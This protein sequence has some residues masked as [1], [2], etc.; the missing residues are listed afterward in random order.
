MTYNCKPPLVFWQPGRIERPD[1]G[2]SVVEKDYSQ[3]LANM[4]KTSFRIIGLVLFCQTLKES[5]QKYF[6]I[7]KAH[8]YFNQISVSSYPNKATVIATSSNVPAK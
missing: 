7:K 3:I 8:T 4:P 1:C 6:K 2:V 5:S